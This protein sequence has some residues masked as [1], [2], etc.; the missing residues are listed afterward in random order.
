MCKLENIGYKELFHL[1]RYIENIHQKR[2]V[3]VCSDATAGMARLLSFAFSST[4]IELLVFTWNLE[5]LESGYHH[6]E[7]FE[8]HRKFWDSLGLFSDVR[9]V[10][11]HFP[12]NLLV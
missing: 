12:F 6:V 9:F 10:I 7:V 5:A 11:F 3:E 1:R 2:C 8:E 4:W